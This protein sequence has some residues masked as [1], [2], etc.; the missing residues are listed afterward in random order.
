MTRTLYILV[1]LTCP[2]V[3]T[4]P[5]KIP[6]PQ[7]FFTLVTFLGDSDINLV[8][9]WLEVHGRKRLIVQQCVMVIGTCG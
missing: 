8:Q 2:D 4:L 5:W 6:P 7:I 3:A 1:Y 9:C